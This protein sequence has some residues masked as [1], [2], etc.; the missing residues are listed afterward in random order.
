MANRTLSDL[1]VETTVAGSD[2]L[3]MRKG[4]TDKSITQTKISE[5]VQNLSD[6]APVVVNVTGTTHSV[7]TT[8]R[9]QLIICSIS[10]NCTFTFPGSY[11][12]AREIIVRNDSA[13]TANVIGL[14]NSEVLYPGQEIVFVWNGSTFVKRTFITNFLV[15]TS[16]PSI[17][18]SYKAQLFVDDTNDQLYFATGTSSSADWINTRNVAWSV[19]TKTSDYTLTT[20][21]L[22]KMIIA[23]PNSVQYG[24]L[25]IELPAGSATIVGRPYLIKHGANQGLVGIVVNSGSGN[26]IIFHGQ[27]LDALLIYEKGGHWELIWDGTNWSCHGSTNMIIG[28]KNRAD[29]TNVQIGNGVGYDNKSASVDLTGMVITEATSGFTAIVVYDSAGT[30]A[31][32]DLYYYNVSSGFTFWTND[33][34]L[35]ASDG[36]TCDVDEISGSSKDQN[37]NFYHGFGVSINNYIVRSFYN[38]SASFTGAI[39]ITY[40]NGGDDVDT[41]SI[42]N[43]IALLQNDVNSAI[44]QTDVDGIGIINTSGSQST[45][46]VTD[47]YIYQETY[48]SN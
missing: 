39:D 4:L 29:W 3:H 33:R 2:I 32:G 22:N 6:Y 48:F 31:S 30:G 10:S 24:E 15:D 37:S 23:N 34:Q 18:P 42:G 14:P 26:K 5:Y 20:A 47:A 35:T 9:K 25:E 45:V 13:S 16:T 8:I 1:P 28:F 36:T 19:E 27:E 40:E 11:G 17:T 41:G 12:D 43:M 21:D 44:I 38:T 7:S 46:S